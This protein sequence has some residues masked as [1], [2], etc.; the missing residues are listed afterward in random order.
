MGNLPKTLDSFNESTGLYTIDR[1]ALNQ[2]QDWAHALW[3]EQLHPNANL[4]LIECLARWLE[5]RG[6]KVPFEVSYK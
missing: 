2:M 5:Q 1:R 6:V 3:M 4:I